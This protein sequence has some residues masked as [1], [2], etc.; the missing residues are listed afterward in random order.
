MSRRIVLVRHGRTA[1]NLARRGQG[2]TDV[3]L[4]EV[5]LDQARVA[6]PWLAGF[7]PR[8][9]WSSDLSRARVTATYAADHLGLPVRVDERLREFDLGERA[10]VTMDDYRQQHPEEYQQFVRGDF[11][12]VPGAEQVPDVAKRMCDVLGD[13][14]ADLPDGATALVASH[15]SAIK[16]AV[17]GMTGH[18]VELKAL[19]G[20]PNCGVAVL[21][22]TADAPSGWAL[23]AYGLQA[24]A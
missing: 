5:G 24:P 9:V 16:A 3:P 13:V 18:P 14:A 17:L 1:W 21:E 19:V 2:H 10:G 23:A 7:A 15:G 6:A 11:R 22:E 20:L 12:D 8:A 4:D